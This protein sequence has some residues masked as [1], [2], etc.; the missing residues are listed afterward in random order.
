VKTILLES[1]IYMGA[2]KYLLVHISI[3]NIVL[4]KFFIN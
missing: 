4:T 3:K 1:R 2:V